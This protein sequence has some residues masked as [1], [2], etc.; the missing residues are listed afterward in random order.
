[1]V[2]LSG[3]T[4]GYRGGAS[5]SGVDLRICRGDFW[6]IVG[7]NG[8]G[9]STLLKTLLGMLPPLRGELHLAP[10]V[11][12]GYVPQRT[13]L[14]RLFPLSALQ[15]VRLG[16]MGAG[17]GALRGLRGAPRRAAMGALDRLGIAHVARKPFRSLS[18]GQQQRVLIARALV[19][20]P[21]ILVLDEP[22]AGMDIPSESLDFLQDLNRA[23]ETTV[24]M[25][26][27]HIE[28]VASR[29]SSIALINMDTGLFATGGTAE[30]VNTERLS[31]LYRRPIEVKGDCC[32]IHVTA[33]VHGDGVAACGRDPEVAP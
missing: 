29:S 18:G 23:H 5:V 1:M 13:V 14:D 3:G 27:H 17:T 12:F 2:A 8:A 24:L 25:V 10:D 20:E 9:K 22:T 28:V 30:L 16:G 15:V 26:V 31:E 32:E 6:G 33:H 7:P 4:I 21:D 19:R 11:C